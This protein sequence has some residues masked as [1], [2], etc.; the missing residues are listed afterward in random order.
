MPPR[1]VFSPSRV[2]LTHTVAITM[3][4]GGYSVGKL[5]LSDDAEK[6]RSTLPL[7]S[8]AQIPLK[9]SS[10]DVAAIWDQL[11]AIVGED[12]ITNFEGDLQLHSTSDW[13]THEWDPS[14]KPMCVVYPASTDEVS[15]IMKIC[16]AQRIP[17]T[18]FSGGTSLEGHFT[19]TSGGI[20]IDF[21]RMD[22]VL[23]LHKADLDVVVQP[24]V[25]WQGLTQQLAEEN[26]FFPPDPGPGAMIG[27]MV[28]TG[29]SGTNAYRYGT[30]RDWVINLTV[31][32]AD[33]TII[34]TRRRPRKSSA[35]YNLTQLFIGSEG[36]L[37]LVTE[38]TLKLTPL[39]QKT[40]V[41]VCSFTSIRHAANCVAE[42]VGQGI[43]LGAI[44]ILDDAQMKYI[45][46]FRGSNAPQWHEAP[47]L[48]LKFGGTPDGVREQLRIV[49]VLAKQNESLSFSL[50]RNKKEE[51]ELWS[52]RK[53]A[54]W[55][56]MRLME[57]GDHILSSDVAV[58]I[59]R[60]PD[61]IEQAKS[62]LNSLGMIG[63]IVGHAGDG[64][65]HS[66]L[67]HVWL[68]DGVEWL[69]YD[70]CAISYSDLQRQAKG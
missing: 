50:A 45:N 28:G 68:Q 42:I 64:N 58:P 7:E 9:G 6:F 14:H 49:E 17:V 8:A 20:S 60:L 40:S 27:G 4:V 19:P 37:G 34:K 47:T 61:A 57:E 62:H 41:A 16:H 25:G 46:E 32:L 5:S 15:R 66:T 65:F 38:A 54:L 69:T 30:M 53:D 1:P 35:G 43:P 26:L 56:T 44:E 11:A 31:V 21:N 3:A 52:A 10:E 13:S 63:S 70:F 29:C 23:A 67:G 48:F 59:S 12:N 51:D 22:K 18:G 36:T 24:A 39:P 55:A 33:G 2:K